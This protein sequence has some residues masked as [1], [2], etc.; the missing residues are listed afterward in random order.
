MNIERIKRW[1]RVFSLSSLRFIY[2]VATDPKHDRLYKRLQQVSTIEGVFKTP[3][4]WVTFQA[5]DFMEAYVKRNMTVFEWGSGGSTLWFQEKGCKVEAYEH[6]EAW[7]ELVKSKLLNDNK[8]HFK[9]LTKGYTIP[10]EGISSCNIIVIDGRE[11]VAC[12]EHII[13]LAKNG[14][15][16]KGALVLFDDSNRQKYAESL[17]ELSYYAKRTMACSD[18]SSIEISKLTTI[19]LF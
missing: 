16:K 1:H 17:K 14:K 7:Y 4:P 12:A 6:H 2:L 3:Q 13:E 9:N 19:F 18:T 8:V 5:L 10:P 11:R 15:I